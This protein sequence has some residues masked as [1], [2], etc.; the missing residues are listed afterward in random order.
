MGTKRERHLDEKQVNPLG[1]YTHLLGRDLTSRVDIFTIHSLS[2]LP[3]NALLAGIEYPHN[4]WIYRLS[5]L[6]VQVPSTVSRYSCLEPCRIFP[7][8]PLICRVIKRQ[9]TPMLRS[10]TQSK[11]WLFPGQACHNTMISHHEAS[12]EHD[13][14][15]PG[16]TC[17]SDSA[18]L[19]LRI[20]SPRLR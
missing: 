18:H 4:Q 16:E 19:H 1:G 6:S 17:L 9:K 7:L 8:Y 13:L 20:V 2:L 10:K 14:T 3:D 5:V 11:Y 12:R 15:T